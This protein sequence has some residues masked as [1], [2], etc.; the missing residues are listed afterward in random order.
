[1]TRVLLE[2][3]VLFEGPLLNLLRKGVVVLPEPGRVRD[4]A[5]TLADCPVWRTP[6]RL[7]ALCLQRFDASFFRLA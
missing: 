2:E 1:M 3:C 5:F 6:L 7:D 4:R